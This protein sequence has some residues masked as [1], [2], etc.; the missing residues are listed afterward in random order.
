MVLSHNYVIEYN[1]IKVYVQYELLH[2]FSYF[3]CLSNEKINISQS[4]R[5]DSEPQYFYL[6]GD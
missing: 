5:V 4:E 3:W 6:D 2:V 1:F